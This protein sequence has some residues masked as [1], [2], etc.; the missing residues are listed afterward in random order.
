MKFLEIMLSLF[1][2]C[3]PQKND[4]HIEIKR[5]VA[6]TQ[7]EYDK[8]RPGQHDEKTLYVIRG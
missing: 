3:P 1:S 8:I 4:S 7:I 6:L 5:T 2:L